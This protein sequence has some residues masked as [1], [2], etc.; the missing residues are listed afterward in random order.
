MI[1]SGKQVE[2][3][4]NAYNTQ[5]AYNAE[6]NKKRAEKS[7][8]AYMTTGDKI[9]ISRRASDFQLAMKAIKATPDIREEKIKAI[10]EKIAAGTYNIDAEK[11]AQ[12]IIERALIDKRV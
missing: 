4:L 12:R 8:K 3:V 9:E 2:Q 10:K 5:K 11:I 6:E 1:I 7:K